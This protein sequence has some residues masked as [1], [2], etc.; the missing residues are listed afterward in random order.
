MKKYYLPLVLFIG[1]F[2]CQPKPIEEEE[3]SDEEKAL[4]VTKPNIILIAVDDMGYADIGAFGASGI[5]TPHLDKMASEGVKFTDFYSFPTCTPTRAALLTGCYPLRV[6]MHRVAAPKAGGWTE[7]VY[8]FGLNP[9]EQT[10][11]E[12][13]KP[14]G[15]VSTLIGKWHLGHHSPHLPLQQG[16]DE[17]FGFPYS[18][19]MYPGDTDGV[20]DY[21]NLP[22]LEGAQIK[23]LNPTFANLTKRFTERALSFMT[24]NQTKPFFLYLAQPMPH[25]PLGAT[26]S[27][28]GTSSKGLYGDVIQ[29][30]DWS[31]GQIMKKLDQLKIAQKTM[32]IF[33][34]DNGPWITYGNH[35]GSTGGLREGKNTAFE[36]GMRVPCIIRWKN[37][38]PIGKTINQV[39]SIMDILPT[40]LEASQ[41]PNPQKTI[42]G[43][44]F[45]QVINGSSTNTYRESLNYYWTDRLRA[46]RKGKWKLM[47]AH[48]YSSVITIGNNGSPGTT[49]NISLPESLFD[50]SLDPS[51]KV[52]VAAQF[53]AVVQELKN[54]ALAN[55]QLLRSGLR[56]VGLSDEPWI[57]GTR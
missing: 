38:L 22:L 4:L 49:Q 39:A 32:I 29:E 27:F 31:V 51:E 17:F 48:N 42:D 12:L 53:P 47:F 40:I 26:T 25:V 18:H 7:S 8:K 37:R 57:P 41:A 3:P 11:A 50:L 19:D 15:Y 1:L 55:D 35:A 54:L 43:K 2:S 6:G 9:S 28:L 36:G 14:R 23:E 52:N 34:S 33:V 24:T 44:S 13:L 20:T 30:L 46:I 5:S 45:W 21:P 16:F 56:P 10:I